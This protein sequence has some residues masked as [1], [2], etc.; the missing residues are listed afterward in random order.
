MAEA[1]YLGVISISTDDSTYTVLACTSF[2]APFTADKLD[3]TQMSAGGQW[4]TSIQGLK[5]AVGTVDALYSASE[6]AQVAIR[7]AFASGATIY[8]KQLFNGTNGFKQAVKVMNCEVPNAVADLVTFKA[9]FASQA[10]P[11][12]LP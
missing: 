4:K 2:S 9:E 11:T 6:T 8:V 5:E 10:A 7:T 1:S 12:F 3:T